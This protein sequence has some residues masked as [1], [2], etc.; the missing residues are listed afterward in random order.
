MKFSTQKREMASEAHFCN[1][2]CN[3][4]E[5]GRIVFLS[6]SFPKWLFSTSFDFALKPQCFMIGGGIKEAQR[7]EK[8]KQQIVI[9]V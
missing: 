5:S 7:K 8:V 6:A 4:R 3:K 9:T 2:P 1:S